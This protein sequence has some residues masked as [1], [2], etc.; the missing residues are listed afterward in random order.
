MHAEVLAAVPTLFTVDG[1]LDLPA[2][3]LLYKRLAGRVSGVFVAGTTGEF[4]ALEHGERVELVRAALEVFGPDAVVAHV[5]AASTRQSVRL[6]RDVLA[7]GA[8]RLAALTPYYLPAD[9]AAVRRHF[10][11]ITGAAGGAEVYGYLFPERSGIDVTPPEFAAMAAET[12]LAGAKLSGAAA[13]ALP[14]F[15][16]A[17]P[18]GVRLWSGADAALASVVRAGGAGVVSGLSAAEP[19]PFTALAAAVAAGDAEA[20]REA[21]SRAD[22]VLAALGGTPQGIKAALHAQGIGT[23]TMR[24]PVTVAT[25]LAVR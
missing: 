4:P 12:G 5:G 10:G 8:R 3:A 6:T 23:A 2:N 25:P 18:D 17:L 16:A 11:A 9:A 22:Q 13:D 1:E 21:Q 7:L 19:E 15:R 20:E 24:M 14:A